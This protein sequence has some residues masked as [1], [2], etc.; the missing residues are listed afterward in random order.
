MLK[1][2]Q[3][4]VIVLSLIAI[5]VPAFAGDLTDNL[6]QEGEARELHI[7]PAGQ[8]IELV[9]GLDEADFDYF[10]NTVKVCTAK[11]VEHKVDVLDTDESAAPYIRTAE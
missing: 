3:T 8:S 9:S 4:T 6:F 7:V 11:Q 1:K 10:S 2:I 5:A